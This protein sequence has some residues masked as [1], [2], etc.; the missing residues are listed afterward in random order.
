MRHQIISAS[1]LEGANVKTPSDESIG[2]IKEIMIDI[3]KS[4][5]SYAVL[6]VSTGFLNLESKYFAV[7]LEEFNFDHFGGDNNADFLILDVSREKLENS[8]GFNKDN[9]PS[10]PESEF[11]DTV[12]SYYGIRE[13]PNYKKY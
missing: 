7:P 13:K 10:H 2:Q 4:E 3:S 8:P 9:W 1:S 11:V 12:N 6:S 5:I